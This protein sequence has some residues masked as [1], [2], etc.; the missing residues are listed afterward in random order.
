MKLSNNTV[1]V[2][3]RATE[4]LSA[5]SGAPLVF[6]HGAG[7]IEGFEFLEP[8]ADRFKVIA[9]LR[10]GYGATSLEPML[11]SRDEVADQLA[12]TLQ[13]LELGPA[14]VVGHSV[15]GW[16]S[17][18]LAARHPELVSL[19]VLGSP[20]GLDVPDHR[21]AD[22]STMALP[23]ILA[24]LTNDPSIWD[25]RLPTGPDPDFEAARGREGQALAHL[26]PQTGYDPELPG[27][28]RQ[29]TTPTVLLWG[30]ED[31]VTP[32]GQLPGWQDAISGATAQIFPNTGHLLFHE[33]SGA[34]E[35]IARLADARS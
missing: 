35:A 34:L 4:F 30:D 25:G 11:N 8:L 1:S 14:V 6:I 23:E 27:V 24:T 3:G 29:I 19:L 13:A 22:M 5:G 2:H 16:L 20:Y 28:L 9:L 18:T 12:D 17:A 21:G 26:L 32:V 31:K 10:P 15:G 33:H 7:I